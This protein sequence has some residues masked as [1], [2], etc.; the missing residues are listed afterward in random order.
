MAPP[1]RRRRAYLGREGSAA[2]LHLGRDHGHVMAKY[3]QTLS[4]LLFTTAPFL[5]TPLPWPESVSSLASTGLWSPGIFLFISL[6]SGPQ[7]Q[8]IRPANPAPWTLFSPASCILSFFWGCSCSCFSTLQPQG[9]ITLYFPFLFLI[10]CPS[11]PWPF[12]KYLLI[13]S[14]AISYELMQVFFFS[15]LIHHFFFVTPLVYY[16]LHSTLYLEDFK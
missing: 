11:I 12:I 1:R 3:A 13:K 10:S 5:L 2:D 4:F 14:K 15:F 6:I 16:L 8:A 7:L 9:N